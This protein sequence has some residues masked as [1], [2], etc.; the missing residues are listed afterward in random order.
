MALEK[1]LTFD[2]GVSIKYHRIGSITMDNKDKVLKVSIVSY[3]DD[4]YRIKEKENKTNKDRHYELIKLILAENE[5]IEESRD[6]EQV[7]AWSDEANSIIKNFSENA[8]FEVVTREYEFKDVTDLS[9]SNLY[10]LIKQEEL[11][12]NSEDV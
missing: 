11:F 2:N 5:K 12:I 4:T 9:M 10:S 6:V 7:I 8:S 3:T 1:D